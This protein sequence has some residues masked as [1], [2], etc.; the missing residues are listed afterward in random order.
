MNLEEALRGFHAQLRAGDIASGYQLLEQ[1][2]QHAA[3]TPQDWDRAMQAMLQA[4]VPGAAAA[5]GEQALSRFPHDLELRCQFGNALRMTGEIQAAERELRAVLSARP[6]HQNA[7]VSLAHLLRGEGRMHAAV[8]VMIKHLP[9][10][11]APETLLAAIVFVRECDQPQQAM[12]LV[13]QGLAQDAE[14]LELHTI[15]G[16]LALELG[17]FEQAR[18][19]FRRTLG[20]PSYQQRGWLRLATTHRFVSLDDPDYGLLKQAQERDD[21][22]DLSRAAVYFAL[23]KADADLG[24][25]EEAAAGL[26]VAN[27]I[28]R[29]VSDWSA[30]GYQAFVDGQIARP[31]PVTVSRVP[32]LQA[33]LIVGLPRTG[34]TLAASLLARH[35]QV[36]VRGELNWLSGLAVQIE[37]GGRDPAQMNQA[38]TIYAA[39]LRRDDEPVPCYVDKNPLNFRHLGLAEALLPNLRVIHCVRDAR[40]TALSLWRQMFAHEDNGYAYDFRDIASFARGERQLM[41]HWYDTLQRPFFELHY[42]ALVSDTPAVL[43]Q[44][45][46][47]LGLDPLTEAISN[48]PDPDSVR[49]ASVWQVRQKI[50]TE[51]IQAWRDWLPY[52]PELT[53]Y[54]PET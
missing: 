16:E 52:V 17:R 12:Q 34:T 40:A 26:R 39:Q 54:F 43:R 49:T 47:F 44:L 32:E 1:Q 9:A 50:H 10:T 33:V 37:T 38:A 6:Q 13:Q 29:R 21:L 2:L 41:Q 14:N 15:A 19:Q 46:E 25:L 22:E 5:L 23:A 31:L 45:Y 35:P 4:G 20:S 24:Q 18:V 8:T 28:M 30:N 36:K 51:A 42:E 3:S 27:R 7:A 48:Q 11:P 53:E